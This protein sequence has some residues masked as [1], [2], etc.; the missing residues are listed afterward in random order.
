M[1]NVPTTQTLTF[2]YSAIIDGVSTGLA[3]CTS[4]L[5][6][7]GCIR[8]AGLYAVNALMSTEPDTCNKFISIEHLS[9]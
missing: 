1:L 8:R 4:K 6:N 2:K 3:G 9:S 7:R 5:C